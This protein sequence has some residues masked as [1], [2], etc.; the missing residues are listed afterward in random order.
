MMLAN[1]RRLFSSSHDIGAKEQVGEED[2]CVEMI[3]A[4]G[5]SSRMPAIVAS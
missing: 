3:Y 4:S 1:V 5:T 2:R